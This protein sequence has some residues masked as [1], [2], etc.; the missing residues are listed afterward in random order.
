MVLRLIYLKMLFHLSVKVA[1]ASAEGKKVFIVIV[2]MEKYLW[3]M[4]I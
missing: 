4:K 1:E 2:Q 3:H